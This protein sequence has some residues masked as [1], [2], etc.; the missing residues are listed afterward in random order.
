MN[1]WPNMAAAKRLAV[2][3]SASQLNI[4]INTAIGSGKNE[5]KRK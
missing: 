1:H 2:W 5:E 3:L 4:F